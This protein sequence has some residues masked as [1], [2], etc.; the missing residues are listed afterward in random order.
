MSNIYR[1]LHLVKKFFSL[2]I[3]FQ[4]AES[5]YLKNKIK[6]GLFMLIKFYKV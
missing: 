4:I 5:F 6:N 3:L 2:S 1:V